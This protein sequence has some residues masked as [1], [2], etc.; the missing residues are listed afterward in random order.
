MEKRIALSGQISGTA[1][2][3]TQDGQTALCLH[4]QR[5]LPPSCTAYLLCGTV[6][7]PMPLNG[8]AGSVQGELSPDALLVA[9]GETLL[10]SGGFAGRAQ[11][12]EK[13]R[14]DMRLICFSTADQAQTAAAN[15][16]TAKEEAQKSPPPVSDDVE[17]CTPQAKEETQAPPVQSGQDAPIK[18]APVFDSTIEG[19]SAALMDILKK[20][21]SLF[22]PLKQAQSAP[23]SEAPPPFCPFPNAFAGAV[24]K[25]VPYPGSSRC[26]LEGTLQNAEGR[27]ILHAIAG[28]YAPVPPVPGFNRFLRS[29]DG[30]GYWLRMRKLFPK[31]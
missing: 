3:R 12:F 29:A 16:P 24:W 18:S 22:G 20:A 10:C 8:V 28:E 19:G 2:I 1:H 15:T 11:L 6:L 27:F 17:P 14:R 23:P 7:M 26:Y 31:N 21:Q 4:M 9:A 30:H 13:A 25:K 5:A